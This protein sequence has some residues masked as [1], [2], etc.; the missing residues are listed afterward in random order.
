MV[1][2]FIKALNN[3]GKAN[4]FWPGSENSSYPGLGH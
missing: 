3:A 2:Y 1:K 4:E